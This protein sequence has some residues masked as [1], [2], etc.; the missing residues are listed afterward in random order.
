MMQRKPMPE[1]SHIKEVGYDEKT[2]DL[3][4]VFKNSPGKVYVFHGVPSATAQEMMGA[5]SPGSFFASNIRNE[6]EYD[7]NEEER[8]DDAA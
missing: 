6:Y 1:S 7:K 4:V 5:D 2:G 8:G 3:E